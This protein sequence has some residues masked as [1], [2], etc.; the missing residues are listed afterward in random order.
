MGLTQSRP[1][2]QGVSLGSCQWGAAKAGKAYKTL[3]Y[4]VS[5]HN[6]SYVPPNTSSSARHAVAPGWPIGCPPGQRFRSQTNAVNTNGAAAKTMNLSDWGKRYALALLGV[7]KKVPLSR[8]MQI[9]SDPTTADADPIRPLPNHAA[10]A[11][12]RDVQREHQ[13]PGP[14]EPGTRLTVSRQ[15]GDRYRGKSFIRGDLLQREVHCKGKSL[16]EGSRLSREIR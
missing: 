6:M 5:L 4:L 15:E 8:S 13:A 10:P 14:A 1:Y 3:C 12:Q 16:L 7:P 9:L 2:F 11:G